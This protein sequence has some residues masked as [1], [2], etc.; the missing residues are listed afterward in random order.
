MEQQHSLVC[1]ETLQEAEGQVHAD[2]DASFKQ[3][4]CTLGHR[5]EPAQ[6][7]M[8]PSMPN[9]AT[10]AAQPDQAYRP[11]EQAGKASASK[12]D[13]AMHSAEPDQAAQQHMPDEAMQAS[14]SALAQ[15]QLS[16]GR[17]QASHLGVPDQ[18]T[19]SADPGEPAH[20]QKPVQAS[21]LAGPT[22]AGYSQQPADV[23]SHQ[24]TLHGSIAQQQLAV[25][26]ARHQQL[27]Q[28]PE[29]Q[30]MV[31]RLQHRVASGPNYQVRHGSDISQRKLHA[32]STNSF[33]VCIVKSTAC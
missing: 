33:I 12:P 26:P 10:H 4:P 2:S 24:E 21:Q 7:V 19:G 18:V 25:A 29:Q 31:D 23:H 15:A 9:E 11:A 17:H 16:A 6:Q 20:Q 14:T 22:Q 28:R 1:T 8:Q 5:H 32:H 3:L 13:Q 27:A 30:T